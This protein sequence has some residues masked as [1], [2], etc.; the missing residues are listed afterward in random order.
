MQPVDV[1]YLQN[2]V[3]SGYANMYNVA[4]EG[5]GNTDMPA[6]LIVDLFTFSL[7]LNV[8]NIYGLSVFNCR[9]NC[10]LVDKSGK[11]NIS[12][13]IFALSSEFLVKVLKV[14]HFNFTNNILAS[15]SDSTAYDHNFPLSVQNSITVANNIVICGGPGIGFNIPYSDCS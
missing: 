9:Y 3:Q 1:P 4:V 13:S 10:L 11:I 12:S 14:S 5:F 2:I 6:F 7:P 15:S 8:S